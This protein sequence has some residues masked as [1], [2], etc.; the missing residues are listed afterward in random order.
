MTDELEFFERIDET[1]SFSNSPYSQNDV[2]DHPVDQAVLLSYLERHY[3]PLDK[4]DTAEY[5]FS[6][7][8]LDGDIG[9][10]T[11]AISFLS[12]DEIITRTEKGKYKLNTNR[13]LVCTIQDARTEYL[14]QKEF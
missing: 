4:E 14:I 7:V 9:D 5:V 1:E 8:G 2:P 12:V 3:V 11:R 6:E 10:I 13:E